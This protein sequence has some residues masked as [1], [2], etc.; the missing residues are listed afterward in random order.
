[1]TDRHLEAIGAR[2]LLPDEVAELLRMPLVSVWREGREGRLRAA[3][4]RISNRMRFRPDYIARF[5]ETS[6]ETCIPDTGA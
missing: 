1:M 4:V 6:G 2:L 3:V 5:V